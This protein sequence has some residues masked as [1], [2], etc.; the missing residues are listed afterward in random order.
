MRSRFFFNVPFFQECIRPIDLKIRLKTVKE[1]IFI[2]L[3][4]M[5]VY[6]YCAHSFIIVANTTESLPYRFFVL[7]KHAIPRTTVPQKD[8][9]VLFTHEKTNIS[10]IKHVKGVP[11]STIRLDAHRNL[12]V[13]D[14]CVGVVRD[15]TSTGKPLSPIHARIVP[16]GFVFVYAT[17]ERSFDS[18]YQEMG[19]VPISA[20]NGV[21]IALL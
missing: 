9:Y 8:R 6:G 19:L 1:A 4:L 5:L 7:N 10:M 13:D 11:G 12:W 2:L 18:R 20:I 15:T 17:H 16:E 3:G 21:G 14:F